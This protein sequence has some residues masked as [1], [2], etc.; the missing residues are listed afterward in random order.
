MGPNPTNAQQ[1]PTPPPTTGTTPI[2]DPPSNQKEFIYLFHKVFLTDL[3][4]FYVPKFFRCFFE[5]EDG[6]WV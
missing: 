2:D 1:H 3:H 6:K 5:I 4:Y